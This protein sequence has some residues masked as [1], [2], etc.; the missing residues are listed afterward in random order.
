M[1]ILDRDEVAAVSIT[2]DR[3]P[4]RYDWPDLE[5]AEHYAE[6]ALT[7]YMKYFEMVKEKLS[8]ASEATQVTGKAAENGSQLDYYAIEWDRILK[9]YIENG[10]A[11]EDLSQIENIL[12]TI[13]WA[14]KENYDSLIAQSEK[15]KKIMEELSSED[16]KEALQAVQDIQSRP[17][18]LSGLIPEEYTEEEKRLSN[19]IQNEEMKIAKESEAFKIILPKE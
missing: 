10:A 5:A 1:G 12:V 18:P 9:K 8:I 13:P 16:Y 2:D 6:L 7:Y 19:H 4:D 11:E 17:N 3:H 14:I 15:I